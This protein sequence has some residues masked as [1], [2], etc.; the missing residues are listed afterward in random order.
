MAR[1]SID[2]LI[3][4]FFFFT[5]RTG[6]PQG[7]ELGLIRPNFWSSDSCFFS[8]SSSAGLILSGGRLIGA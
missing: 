1:K 6:V 3:E 8:S 5:N 2:I 4:P 7:D